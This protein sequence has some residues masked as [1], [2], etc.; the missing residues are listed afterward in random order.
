VLC[1][2]VGSE[3]FVTPGFVFSFHF[4]KRITLRLTR[5]LKLP[6]TLG[7]TEAL[8]I[9]ALHPFQTA[10]HLQIVTSLCAKVNSVTLPG[11]C[12]I[13][14]AAQ[15]FR[16]LARTNLVARGH[17]E[18]SEILNPQERSSNRS[19]RFLLG[20]RCTC[21]DTSPWQ[22]PVLFS[23]ATRQYLRQIHLSR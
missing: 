15:S 17:H 11:A 2:N 6:V 13:F 16:A 9:L 7:A 5:G 12:S 8:E 20:C 18:K 3:L 1:A 4:I 19:L 10:W 22:C 23:R 14:S 21:A